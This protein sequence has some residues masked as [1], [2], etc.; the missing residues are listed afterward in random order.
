MDFESNVSGFAV[1]YVCNA[2]VARTLAI[3]RDGDADD[4]ICRSLLHIRVLAVWFAF[5]LSVVSFG[6][7]SA[8]FARLIGATA[9]AVLKIVLTV[10]YG[11]WAPSGDDD[12]AHWGQS[13][14]HIY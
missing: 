7:L 4:W 14:R 13:K 10:L 8:A 2:L 11:G 9:A 5:T 1:V 3:S 12:V 6:L